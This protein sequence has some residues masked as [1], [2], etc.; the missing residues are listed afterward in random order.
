[1]DLSHAVAL[2]TEADK[3]LGKEIA[4]GLARLGVTVLVGARD[5]GSADAV[6]AELE[7]DGRV[8]PLQLDLADQASIEAAFAEIDARYGRLN[9]LVNNAD[10]RWPRLPPSQVDATAMHASFDTNVSSIVA[11]TNAMLPLLR[12]SLDAR[13]VNIANLPGSIGE[14]EAF[15]RLPSMPSSTSRTALDAITLQYAR[16]LAA[17]DIKVN[18]AALG[19][20]A[21]ASYNF[22]AMRTPAEGVATAIRLATLDVGGP[23]GGFF[24]ET[25]PLTW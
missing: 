9:I 17:T 3:G 12:R 19:Q 23:T 1:M 7:P 25:G 5:L 14:E 10:A 11:G 20:I 13:I 4:R 16:E 15:M 24:D 22:S 2:V 8:V 18:A 21:V 6:A